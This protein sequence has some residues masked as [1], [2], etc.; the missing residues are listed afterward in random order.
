M[1]ACVTLEAAECVPTVW[2]CA[3]GGLNVGDTREATLRRYAAHVLGVE[4]AASL[5]RLPRVSYSDFSKGCLRGAQNSSYDF[6]FEQFS[7]FQ[8]LLAPK[9]DSMAVLAQEVVRVLRPGGVAVLHGAPMDEHHL[10]SIPGRAVRAFPPRRCLLEHS[11]PVART[12]STAADPDALAADSWSAAMS[13]AGGDD[14]A[15]VGSRRARM[16]QQQCADVLLF[17]RNATD[18]TDDHSGTQQVVMIR[19]LRSDACKSMP[20]AAS[21]RSHARSVS[22]QQATCLEPGPI[23]L[24]HATHSRADLFFGTFWGVSHWFASLRVAS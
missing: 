3:G 19:K 13:I 14:I 15:V 23:E 12:S 7:L 4:T 6:V 5:K 1:S 18:P 17:C 22:S 2:L 8:A 16:G 9:E 20:S 24:R 11:G 10:A 21:T